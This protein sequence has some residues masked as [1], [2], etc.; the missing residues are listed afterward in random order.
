[1]E[2]TLNLQKRSLKHPPKGSP[3]LEPG[4]LKLFSLRKKGVFF[5]RWAFTCFQQSGSGE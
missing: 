3:G 5:F 4:K 2:A 1:M